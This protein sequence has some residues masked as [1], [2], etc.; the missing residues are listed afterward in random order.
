[1][2]PR[3]LWLLP[4]APQ[5]ADLAPL[6]VDDKLTATV[7]YRRGLRDHE[8]VARFLEPEAFATQSPFEVPGTHE[9]VA[10]L[11]WALARDKRIVIYGDY[12]VDGLA[13]TALMLE[14]LESLDGRAQPYIPNRLESG[15]GL[16][17]GA[18]RELAAAADV[19]VTVD[20]G[21]RSA[22]EV[23]EARR[24]GMSVIVTDHHLPGEALPA[25][26]AVVSAKRPGGEAFTD[27]AGV[28]IA[29]QLMLALRAVHS[30][31][32]QNATEGDGFD[33]LVALGTIADVA[34]LVGPNR[35]LV[36]SGLE[37]LR[38]KPR[39]G[40][41]AI[42]RAAGVDASELTAGRVAYSL[43][44]RLN[45][46]GRMGSSQPALEL[47][48]TRDSRRAE[49]LAAQLERTNSQRRAHV[50]RCLALARAEL[51]GVAPRDGCIF[52][53]GEA[54][55]RGVLGLV[56]SRLSEQFGLPAVVAAVEGETAHGS[57]RCA[58]HLDASAA[59]DACDGLLQRHGGHAAAAGFVCATE[60]LPELR[61]RLCLLIGAG[62]AG[63]DARPVLEV[64]A[65]ASLPA[66]CS[67][68]WQ[69]LPLL[70]P[71]GAGNPRPTL[72]TRDVRLEDKQLFGSS[73]EH[74]RL[75]LRSGNT[76]IRAVAFGMAGDYPAIPTRL[77]IAYRLDENTYNGA[78]ER[79]LSLEDWQ[80]TEST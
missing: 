80:P 48:T 73:S 17:M 5:R 12:D 51:A 39:V 35:R 32:G 6:E 57:I 54:Y 44:P 9:A 53:A 3:F 65:E 4:P 77:D 59:L 67:P 31:F 18:V 29:Q 40:I 15:Y 30:R 24:L 8:D 25:A 60:R 66:H 78:T 70:E 2:A 68:L 69:W 38:G 45:A 41:R 11:R 21:I 56:A 47:L 27:L 7:L 58:R 37:M 22:E 10:L 28:G 23:A 13:A 74:L 43:A 14:G 72:V 34:P 75:V 46:A 76:F 61:D 63:R 64:D 71:T 20:C 49:A 50:D 1:M 55:Q 42:L 52:T 36:R 79:R 26:D 62:V 19:L 33:D 16:N